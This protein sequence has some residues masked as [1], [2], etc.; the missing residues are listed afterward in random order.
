M[1]EIVY[2]MAPVMEGFFRYEEKSNTLTY[3][4]DPEFSKFAFMA[5]LEIKVTLVGEDGSESIY[6]QKVD[7]KKAAEE[8]QQAE[9]VV[10][11]GEFTPQEE[12]TAAETQ[13]TEELVIE[14]VV[15]EE[16]IAKEVK[17]KE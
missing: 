4:G 7:F 10:T 1:A 2:E 15:N 3:Y 8:T 13:E 11:E 12:E 5:P 14:E 9:S 6:I 17:V 16:T